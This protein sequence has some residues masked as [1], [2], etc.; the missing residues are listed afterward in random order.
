MFVWGKI[1]TIMT[2][3]NE[4]FTFRADLVSILFFCAGLSSISKVL[5]RFPCKAET[6]Y[7]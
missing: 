2:A 6:P 4:P 1:W 7:I 3:V 5:Q